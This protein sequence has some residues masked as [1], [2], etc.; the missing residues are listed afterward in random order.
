[1]LNAHLLI[2][3]ENC[4]LMI[5]GRYVIC[6]TAYLPPA[7]LALA[8]ALAPGLRIFWLRYS[9]R[10]Q[11][12]REQILWIEAPISIGPDRVRFQG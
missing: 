10:G 3:V 9:N 11:F 12:T 1:V 2:S 5:P 4:D 7:V 6:W 8:T